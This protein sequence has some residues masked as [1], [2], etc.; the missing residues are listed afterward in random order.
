MNFPNITEDEE[1]WGRGG[2]CV[3]HRDLLI[4]QHNLKSLKVL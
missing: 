1:G 2:G 3:P 4:P